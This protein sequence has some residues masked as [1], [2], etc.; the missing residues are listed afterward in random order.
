MIGTINFN[1][2]FGMTGVIGG[3]LMGVGA[4]LY[5]IYNTSNL[6]IDQQQAVFGSGLMVA[7]A[8]LL[9][10][11]GALLIPAIIFSVLFAIANKNNYTIDRAKELVDEYNRFIE[12][13]LDKPISFLGDYKSAISELIFGARVKL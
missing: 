9:G 5:N 2:W 8:V 6:W 3:V 12:K 1:I 11:S 13:Q 4:G 7:G 10:I